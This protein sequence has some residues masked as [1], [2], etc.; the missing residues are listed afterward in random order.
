MADLSVLIRLH[1]HELDEKRRALAGLYAALSVRQ[2]ERAQLERDFQK[3]KEDIAKNGDVHFT[4]ADYAEAVKEKRAA[5]LRQ[6]RALEEQI[7]QARESLM[8]TFSELKKYEMT[9]QER[10]KL[11]EEERRFKEGL[12]L[13][14][15]ALEGFRRKE[16]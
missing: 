11:E 10:E 15:I 8:G 9:Q 2:K 6:E 16:D 7:E 13:D 1:K 5:L 3:E 4:F 14:E 12:A